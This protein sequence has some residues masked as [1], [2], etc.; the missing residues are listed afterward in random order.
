MI[1]WEEGYVVLPNTSPLG[2]VNF[3]LAD[4]QNTRRHLPYAANQ[5]LGLQEAPSQMHYVGWENAAWDGDVSPDE[6][7]ARVRSSQAPGHPV[8]TRNCGESGT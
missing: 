6:K 3:T 4:M 5:V 2:C 7:R 1:L 8:S